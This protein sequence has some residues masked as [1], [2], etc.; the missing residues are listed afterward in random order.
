[1]MPDTATAVN[2]PIVFKCPTGSPCPTLVSLESKH[3]LL[4]TNMLQAV[5]AI[6]NNHREAISFLRQIDTKVNVV[7]AIQRASE[8]WNAFFGLL[9]IILVLRVIY[10][11]F[12]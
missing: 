6:G 8:N 2:A 4:A 7:T 11:I 9:V 12:Y 10:T 3:E 1:M 5:E